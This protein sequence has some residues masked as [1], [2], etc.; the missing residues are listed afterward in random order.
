MITTKQRAHLKMLA[1]NLQPAVIVGKEAVSENVVNQIDA[2]LENKELVKVKILKSA[3]VN[4]KDLINELA[5][6][7]TAEPILAVGGVMVFYRY[8]SKKGIKHI[9]LS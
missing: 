3:D 7:L 5:E 2:I 1:H 4:A 9:A 8:S 6:K